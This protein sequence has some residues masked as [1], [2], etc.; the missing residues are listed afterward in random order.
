MCF[1]TA[2]IQKNA[3]GFDSS[4]FLLAEVASPIFNQSLFRLIFIALGYC[5]KML[6][7]P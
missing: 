2:F 7:I 5:L 3:V 1:I 4:I 6:K